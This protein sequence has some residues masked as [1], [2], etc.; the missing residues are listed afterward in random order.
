[1]FWRYY[2]KLIKCFSNLL[3]FDHL[4]C[5]SLRNLLTS[6]IYI[7]SKLLETHKFL[8]LV[9]V[10]IR[11]NDVFELPTNSHGHP[12]LDPWAIARPNIYG[13]RN[14]QYNSPRSS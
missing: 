2:E 13:F 12:S 7:F 1:M 6:C 4:L 8:A 14:G 10:S 9:F 11:Y 3:C 5:K